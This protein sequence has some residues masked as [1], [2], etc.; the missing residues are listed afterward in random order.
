[1]GGAVASTSGL[2]QYSYS[3]DPREPGQPRSWD[4]AARAPA[5]PGASVPGGMPGHVYVD[6]DGDDPSSGL[7]GAPTATMPSTHS[8]LTGYATGLGWELSKLCAAAYALPPFSSVL[9]LLYE[10]QN[11]RDRLTLGFGAVPCVPSRL[12]RRRRHGRV[13]AVEL[14]LW[15]VVACMATSACS[16]LWF[17]VLRV[18]VRSHLGI[19][20]MNPPRRWSGSP[21]CLFSAGMPCSV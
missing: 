9:L 14:A 6:V 11:V 10:V 16:S 3:R 19:W 12:W 5:H 20:R 18:R 13:L 1:M 17:V 2:P 8:S 4:D 21:F 7:G 15:R